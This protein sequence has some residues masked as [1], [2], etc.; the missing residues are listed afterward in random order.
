M[1][2][3]ILL[4]LLFLSALGVLLFFFYR[5]PKEVLQTIRGGFFSGLRH[6]GLF[7]LKRKCPVE[8]WKWE[9]MQDEDICEDCLERASWPATDI[10]DWMK[11]GLPGT[12]EAETACGEHC[13][14]E[15]VPYKAQTAIKK[16]QEI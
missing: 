12:P 15:L 2:R 16:K 7:S 6:C 8:L 9:T 3:L 11:E 14:C 13:R 1:F 4:V 10:A 5:R